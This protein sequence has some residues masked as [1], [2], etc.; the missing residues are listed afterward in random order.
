MY[1]LLQ[2]RLEDEKKKKTPGRVQSI[3]VY[4]SSVVRSTWKSI[5]SNINLWFIVKFF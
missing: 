4:D 3:W 1:T 2:L 5:I